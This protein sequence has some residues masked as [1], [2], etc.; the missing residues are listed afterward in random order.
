[1]NRLR[2]SNSLSDASRHQ[3]PT[4]RDMT[5]Q[6]RIRRLWIGIKPLRVWAGLLLLLLVLSGCEDLASLLPQQGDVEEALAF[7]APAA[8]PAFPPGMSTA[9][10]IQA[11]GELVV[12]VRYDLEP[13]SYVTADSQLAGL[14]IDLARELARRW[15]GS[16][17]AVRF[18]QIRSDTAYQYLAD[19]LVD[20]A[21]GGLGHTQEAEMRADFSP[22]YF[23]NGMAL[24]TFPDAGIQSQ[25]DLGGKRIG[26]V[27]WTDSSHQFTVGPT[28]TATYVPYSHYFDLVEA[29]RAREIDAYADQRHRLERARRAVTGT[30]I[31]GQWTHEPVAMIYR[32]DDPVF[33]NLVRLTF[34]DMVVDGTRDTL[35]R[36]WLPD[37][38]PPAVRL[39]PGSAPTPQLADMAQQISTLDMIGRIRDRGVVR[40][41]YFGQRWPYSADREDGVPTGFELRVL[42]R[43]VETWLGSSS[44]MAY[45]PIANEAEGLQRLAQGE[46]DLLAG[47]WIHTRDLELRADCSIPIL[48]DGVGIMSLA[49]APIEE[50]SQL[51]GQ[52]VAVVAG[53]A[54]EAAVPQLSQGV[55]LSA[56]GYASFDAALAALQAGEVRAV[57]SERQPALAVHFRQS[58]FFFTDHRYTYRPVVFVMPEGDSEFVDLVNLT[59]MSLEDRGIY[60]EL[61]ELWFEDPTPGLDVWPGRPSISLTIQR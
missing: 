4:R 29:L 26:I 17:A 25:A 57:L 13:F 37:T 44:A 5:D 60:Q 39:L 59:L 45:V 58:G 40:V 31:V 28:I 32:H 11:R 7:V 20:I 46:V 50:L 38:S 48:D 54:A 12:G 27:T 34:Q 35:F 23:V 10:R 42:E 53:S 3:A 18:R 2:R 9:A 56:A 8:E 55:G 61:Y 30:T 19:G 21:L 1:V 36:R 22:P 47:N 24:L 43:M 15:L 6:H 52:P 51:A 16:S 49:A 41:G 14:E 33:A